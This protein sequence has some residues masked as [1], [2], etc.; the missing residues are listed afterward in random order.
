MEAELIF[1]MGLYKAA[2]P[3]TLSYSPIHFWFQAQENGRTRCG[4]TS[5]A[6][7]LLGDLFRV[8]W[9]IYVGE[10]VAAE[11]LIGEVESTKATSEFYAPMGGKLADINHVVV[12][13]PSLLGLNPY[14]AWL[15]EFDGAPADA[16][17]PEAYMAFLAEGWDETVKLLK[18]Q[19]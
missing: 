4:L 15:L 12:G 2:I 7:R 5:Y 19:A 11:Q 8:E 17:T 14:D 13:E 1:E 16:L 3:R 10:A 9:K 6:A 18:G